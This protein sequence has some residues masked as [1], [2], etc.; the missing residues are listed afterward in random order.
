MS[1]ASSESSADERFGRRTVSMPQSV[2]VR[3]DQRV[4]SR[5]FSAYV[6]EAVRR[7][8]E[9]DDLLELIAEFGPSDPEADAIA[10]ARL[11]AALAEAGVVADRG[12][13]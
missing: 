3:V 13:Q 11:E 7:Q 9:R 10:D 2:L 4:A 12:A 1:E 5:E 6:T 8:L